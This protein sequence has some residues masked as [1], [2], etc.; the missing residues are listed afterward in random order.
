MIPSSV[1]PADGFEV[2]YYTNEGNITS[3]DTVDNTMSGL[4]LMGLL[5]LQ[6]YSI[7]VVGFKIGDTLPSGR[8]NLQVVPPG[9]CTQV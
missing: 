4:T 1:E 3:G 7:F 6:Q 2:F 5:P 8:S 9:E